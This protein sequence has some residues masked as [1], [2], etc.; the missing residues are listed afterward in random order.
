MAKLKYITTAIDY[1][2]ASPHI[3]HA[4]QKIAAD[5]L[6]RWLSSYGEKV[7]FQTGTDEHGLK[8]LRSAQ[9]VNKNPQDFVDEISKKFI[10]AWASLN[11]NYSKFFRTTDLNHKKAVQKFIKN[12]NRDIYKGKYK[13]Y[14]CVGC[15]AYL[16]EDDIVEGKCKIHQKPV[17]YLEEETYF[18]K[19][20]K[21]A[22][23]LLEFYKENPSFIKPINRLEEVRQRILREGLK[24]LSITRTKFSWGIPFPL[25]KDHVV[26]VWFDA[27]LNYLT[28]CGWPKKSYE[29]IWPPDY[30]FLGV[31]NLWFHAVIW[32]AM[33]FSLGLTPPKTLVINGWVTINGQKISKSLGNVIE[34]EY[35]VE[36]YGVDSVRY[37]F[38]RCVPYG[39]DLDF[40][41]MDLAVRH[42]SELVHELGNLVSRILTLLEKFTDSRVPKAK[43]QKIEE[44]EL[45]W[46]AKETFRRA[47]E[48]ILNLE[49]HKALEEI[50]SFIHAVNKYI[51]TEKPWELVKKNTSH[52]STVLYNLTESLRIIAA[53]IWPFMP[54]TAERL[55]TQLGLKKVPRLKNLSWGKFKANTKI[56]KGS[57]LFEE[58]DLE[59]S[60]LIEPFAALDLKVAEIKAVEDVPDTEKLYKLKL[61]L[62]KYG[63]REIV[64]GIKQHYKPEELIGKKI[65]I[66]AN[67]KPA[68]IKT[69][70]SQGMLLACEE[71]SSGKIGVLTVTESEPGSDVFVMGIDKKP[72]EELDLD[73]FV[74]IT[75]ITKAGS[76]YYKNKPLQTYREKVKVENVSEGKIR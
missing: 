67:L 37:Y 31:D 68:K 3:G 73:Q 43:K 76:V 44:L 59:K 4:Y 22:G 15:E 28:G 64:A 47:N 13:G 50:W 61:S 58:I 70:L 54:K 34:P 75:L 17:E 1:V 41:E 69:I 42:N 66:V 19:L 9:S 8:I 46:K 71:K 40:K 65:V 24:D 62:G 5:V 38:M 21:Y 55:S 26:Y 57:H 2:N 23:K 36:K 12:I 16:S 74:K 7:Y 60:N 48:K 56:I 52:L 29:K 11:I 49:F 51:D 63:Y 53:L 45:A 39:E 18:F 72:V 6:A 14:Y 30:Q 27:L 10:S 35:L 25:E 33:L 20:S 32:P